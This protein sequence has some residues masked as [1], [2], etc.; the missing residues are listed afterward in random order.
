M[1]LAAICFL[2]LNM[3]LA[4]LC[5]QQRRT[6]LLVWLGALTALFALTSKV[7]FLVVAVITTGVLGGLPLFAIMGTLG[8]MLLITV[9]G[10]T[11]LDDLTIVVRKLLELATKEVL[12]AIPFFVVAGELMTKGTLAKRMIDVMRA[13]FGALPGGLA[14]AAVAG[15][16]FF[17]AISGSSPVTVVAIGSLMVPALLKAGYPD[18]FSIGLLTTAGSLGILIPPSIPMIVYAIMVSSTTPVDPTEL[19]M[20]GVLPGLFIGALLALYAM[21]AGAKAGVARTPFS[22]PA[23]RTALADGIWSMCLPLLILGGIYGGIFTATEAAAV[24]VLYALAVE[25]LI[26]RELPAK[27]LIDVAEGSMVVMGSLL[28]IIALAITL[29]Y[30]LVI[31]EVPDRMVEWLQSLQLSRNSFLIIVNLLLLVVG[32]FMD[33][34]SAILILAPMLAPMADAVGI[35]PIHMGIIFIVNLEIGYLT[36]PVG[37]NL[38]VSSTLFRKPLGFVVRSVLPTLFIML[39]SLVII[40]WVPSFSTAL[41][42]DKSVPT[43]P[44]PVPQGDA[45]RPTPTP[46]KVK[47][48]EE[49]M[50]EQGSAPNDSAPG[51]DVPAT[52]SRVKSL[53]EL[54]K[55]QQSQES[56]AVPPPSSPTRVKS[57][58]ELMK[59]QNNQAPGG[60]PS[61]FGQGAS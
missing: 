44:A 35:H 21:W 26:H 8:T 24:S 31:E 51:A 11:K 19:F 12:L 42:P 33:I 49:L 6:A 46:G 36:P 41:L 27:K 29:N 16:V 25:M 54:M 18:G 5:Y 17:A 48:M 37:L 47:S 10:F 34:M 58:E 15:C 23:L 28:V 38:F 3:V 39:I 52:P 14:V 55:E 59:E 40:T 22:W 50:K 7:T 9:S 57:L 32:C 53:E 1:T 30:F 2:A 13:M 4:F 56:N 60:D 45:P 43:Q 20:A 61:A